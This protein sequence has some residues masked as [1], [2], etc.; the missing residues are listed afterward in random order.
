MTK[1]GYI[2]GSIGST[3]INRD[4]AEALVKLA[5]EGVEFTEIAIKDLPFFSTD[6]EVDLPQ[7]VSDFKAAIEGV[8]GVIIA[9]PE[10]SRSIP[11]VLKNAIEW[12]NR[13]YGQM[14]FSG[15]PV[16]VIGGSP[17]GIATAA[18]QQHLR[19]VLGHSDA[20]VM[21]QPEGFI[22]VTPGLIV[23]GEITNEGTKEFLMAY[24][25]A[26]LGLVGRV[27]KANA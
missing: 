13:P 16:G 25:G 2:V 18:A 3:S 14:S 12:S 26:F 6:L 1:I 15:T 10:Y 27:Q 11:G 7:V 9:T 20:I 4:L 24:L 8:D 19:A 22:Q 17:G 21:G 23:D 5:P